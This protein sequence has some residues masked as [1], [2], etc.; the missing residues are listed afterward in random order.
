MKIIEIQTTIA[1]DT[2]KTT[3]TTG[4][5]TVAISKTTDT[6]IITIHQINNKTKITQTKNHADIV[7]EQIINP[8]IVKLVLIAEAWDMCL[9]N[10]EHLD[11]IKTIGKKIR[12]L[13]KIHGITIKT[14]T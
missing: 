11:K 9:A 6:T 4:T 2:T 1:T 14:T 13:T 8:R 10:A 12:M 7:T 3:I 5:T